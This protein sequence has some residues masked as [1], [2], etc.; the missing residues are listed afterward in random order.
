MLLKPR[1]QDCYLWFRS[2]F[3]G[4]RKNLR[5]KQATNRN[6]MIYLLWENRSNCFS[7]KENAILLFWLAT[8]KTYL[9]N[10]TNN[11]F[12]HLDGF[13]IESH[14]VNVRE[15][16]NRILF[17]VVRYRDRF[18][19]KTAWSEK[20]SF[21]AR[22]LAPRRKLAENSALKKVNWRHSQFWLLQRR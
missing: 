14:S 8:T 5:N 18:Q 11:Q 21:L 1:A 12:Q 4:P 20:P 6:V 15:E 10:N 16:D 13:A 3:P 17:T 19:Q 2:V 9:C 7:I 22:E